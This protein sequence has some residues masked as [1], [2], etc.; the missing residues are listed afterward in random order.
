METIPAHSSSQDGHEH[1][2]NARQYE[3]AQRADAGEALTCQEEVSQ[4]QN[5]QLARDPV[6]GMTLDPQQAAGSFAYQGR[7]Y[8]FCSHSCLE[9][10]KKDPAQFLENS[11]PTPIGLKRAPKPERAIT[12]GVSPATSHD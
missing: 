4:N 6:C 2:R 9:K 1:A 5:E 10:F 11:N 12:N 7:T 8:F 3:Q